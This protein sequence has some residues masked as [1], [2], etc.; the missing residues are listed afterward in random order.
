MFDYLIVGQGLAGTWLSHYLLQAGKT[1]CVIDNGDKRANSSSGIASGIMNPITGKR[2]VKTWQ[3]D[4]VL[5]FAHKAYRELEGLLG[6]T[7]FDIR[8]I[9]WLLHQTEDLNRLSALSAE[10]DYAP[11]IGEVVAGHF[12]AELQA[13]LGYALVNTGCVHTSHFLGTY[14]QYLQAQSAFID[15]NFDYAEL[16]LCENGVV[17]REI[18]A[19]H[20]IFCEGGAAI[21]R[22]PY[23]SG[24]PYVPVKGEVLYIRLHNASF[25]KHIIK[26]GVF[27]LHLQ[28]DIYWVG[29]NYDHHYADEYPT[30]ETRQVLLQQLDATLSCTYEV[31]GQVAAIRPASH[32][33]RPFVGTHPKHQ[34][35]SVLNGLG[36]KGVSLA[37]YYAAQLAAHLMHGTAIDR[38]VQD[39]VVGL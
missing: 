39:W 6:T 37:P 38:A 18:T 27:I 20:L 29:S 7:F 28:D 22:N 21:G 26:N 16:Q 30:P 17:W 33:R 5:P 1:V 10:P 32:Y 35:L 3:A 19:R 34:Q 13:H 12:A 25:R 14:R 2:F 8:P 36:T 15:A 24:L 31:L 23:F 11:Y 9:V 4:T